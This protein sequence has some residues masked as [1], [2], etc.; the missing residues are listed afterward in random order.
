MAP[1]RAVL[2]WPVIFFLAI[3]H[4]VAL[5]HPLTEP[6]GTV[7]DQL[8]HSLPNWGA[9]NRPSRSAPRFLPRDR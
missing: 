9:G 4:V 1:G 8:I 5:A 2:D 7:I 6:P 3:V